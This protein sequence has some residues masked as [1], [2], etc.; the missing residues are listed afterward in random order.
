MGETLQATRAKVGDILSVSSHRLGETERT[1]EILEVLGEGDGEHY[2][3]RWDD[4]HESFFYTSSDATI[5]PAQPRGNGAGAR[6]L[7]GF[8]D[9]SH[10]AYELISHPHSE[11]AAAEALA[12]GVKASEVAKTL[13]L[14]APDGFVRA[15]LPASERL[16]LREVRRILGAKDVHVASEEAL[17]QEYPEFELGAVPPVGGSHRDRVLV[18]R[19]LL[20]TDSILLEAGTHDQS[21]RIRTFDLL[22]IADAETVD[23]CRAQPR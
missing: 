15:V 2:R 17:A 6:A 14:K 12:L 13:V 5:R 16:D 9:E 3:V 23:L 8:L 11:T 18:D 1:G 19:R 20:W 10:V 7:V 21:V 4:G 22:R